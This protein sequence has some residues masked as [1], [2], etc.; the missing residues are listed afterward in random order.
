M[1]CLVKIL[2][3]LAVCLIISGCGTTRYIPVETVRTEIEY[4]D[5]LQ[6]RTDSIHITDSVVIRTKGDT[7]FVEKWRERWRERMIID[8]AFCYI[9][10]TDSISV[11]YPV[12]VPLT[13][14]QQFKLDLGGIAIGV[15]LVLLSIAIFRVIRKY[16]G[17][18]FR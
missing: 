17:F 4:Q 16:R 6:V 8:T 14:W 7:V 9:E 13:K 3:L 15:L 2:V 5:R 10:R 12:P 1:K 11:P 18:F